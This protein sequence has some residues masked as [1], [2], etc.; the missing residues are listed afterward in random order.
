MSAA[1]APANRGYKA[2]Q[3]NNP[4]TEIATENSITLHNSAIIFGH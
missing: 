3:A 1:K 4:A 2:L